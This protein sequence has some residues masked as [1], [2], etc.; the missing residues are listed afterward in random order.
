MMANLYTSVCAPTPFQYALLGY[1]K[2]SFKNQNKEQQN[3]LNLF[4]TKLKLYGYELN[5][6]DGGQYIY[7]K[8]PYN[9]EKFIKNCIDNKL[10]ISPGLD[11]SSKN[12]HFRITVTKKNI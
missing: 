8:Y 3:K 10:V 12:T 1:S 5:R 2:I 11:F 9:P 4:Y 6:P 7:V